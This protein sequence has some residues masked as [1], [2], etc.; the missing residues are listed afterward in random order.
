MGGE[1]GGDRQGRL[2]NI[3]VLFTDLGINSTIY[4]TVVTQETLKLFKNSYM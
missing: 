4:Y 2:E 3:M 1:G